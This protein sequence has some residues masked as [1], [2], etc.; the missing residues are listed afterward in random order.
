MLRLIDIVN[1]LGP[2]LEKIR[3]SKKNNPYNSFLKL[4]ENEVIPESNKK[5][6]L[7]LPIRASSHSNLF[8]GILGYALRLRGYSVHALFCGQSINKCE[9]VDVM[10]KHPILSCSLCNYE[11]EIFANTFLLELNKYSNHVDDRQRDSIIKI[12]NE[13]SVTEFFELTYDGIML[14][15]H[16]KSAVMRYLLVSDVDMRIHEGIIRE[17][18]FSTLMSFEATK[19]LIRKIEPEFV[20]ATH[21]VYS[22]W[23]GAT[24]ACKALNIP[25]VIWD[26]GYVGGNIIASHNESY[27]FE[28]V[29]EPNIYWEKIL[30]TNEQKIQVKEYFLNKKNPKSNVDHVN[31]YSKTITS[32]SESI[33]DLI[34]ASKNKIKFGLFPNIPWDGTTFSSNAGFP[35]IEVFLKVTI[36][37][38]IDHSECDLIIRAHPAETNS[39][40]IKVETIRDVIDRIQPDLPNNIYF[41]EADSSITSYDVE[42][43]CSYCL[44]YAST[45]SLEFSFS[46]STVIQTGQSNVSN[47]GI[48]FEATTI[49]EYIGYLNKAEKNELF[50]SQDMN[51]RA[52][53]YAYHWVY[54]R[55]IPET[56]YT[57]K[58]LEFVNY[59]IESS[60]DLGIGKNKSL[61]WF[62]DCCINKK[63]F[64]WE[65]E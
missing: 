61:D 8:E 35:N 25:F 29:I 32:K 39:N 60:M 65:Y 12:C 38:F 34:G 27:L 56:I 64:I 43:I 48:V 63:P 14:G 9:T 10:S 37:W 7:I 31:Y 57:H 41:V 45:L 26:R 59:N 15:S 52:E 62:L 1:P 17:F 6:V 22:T 33:S 4:R 46:G 3:F 53:K 58:S 50:M 51:S 30:L 23:G 21:G 28:R 24:E 40:N 44:M 19:Q 16:I 2:I 5:K 11:Q 54:R 55:H 47:K 18:A 13:K 42:S 36:E 20:L 49:R